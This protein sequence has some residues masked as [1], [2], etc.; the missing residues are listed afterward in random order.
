MEAGTG[1]RSIF[2]LAPKPSDAVKAMIDGLEQF[3]DDQFQIDMSTYGYK[4]SWADSICYGCA[5]TCALFQL[6]GRRP[7]AVGVALNVFEDRLEA[8]QISRDDFQ[9]GAYDFE[10]VIDSFRCGRTTPLYAYYGTDPDD[11]RIPWIDAAEMWRLSTG[12]WRDQLPKV[13]AYLVR[14]IEAGL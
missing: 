8:L 4:P 9:R 2:E 1:L 7:E 3:P 14:M 5:A 10:L 13:K 11:P 12:N 6:G